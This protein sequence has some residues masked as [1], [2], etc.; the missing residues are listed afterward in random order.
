[1]GYV[2]V[3]DDEGNRITE[4]NPMPVSGLFGVPASFSKSSRNERPINVTKGQVNSGRIRPE[5]LNENAES[6]REAQSV[7]T[8]TNKVGQVFKASQDNINAIYLTLQSAEAVAIDDFESYADD[9]ALQ[10]VWTPSNRDNFI[11]TTIVRDGLQSMGMTMQTLNDEWVMTMAAVDYTG[12][13][14]SFDYFQDVTASTAYLSV[15][16]EDS[17]GNSKHAELLVN[18]A[19]NWTHFDIQEVA[20]IEDQAGIT[21]VTDIIKIGF[22]VDNS[23][24]GALAYIDNLSAAPAPGQVGIQIWDMGTVLPEAG[25]DSINDGTQYTQ[26]GDITATTP[27]SQYNLDL[28]GGKRLYHVHDFVCGVALE[29]PTNEILNVDHY[30]ALVLTYVDTDVTVYGPDSSFDD[31]PYYNNGYAFTAP[32]NS[33]AI[34]QI[35]VNND[36]MFS[37]FST[38]DVYIFGSSARA[39]AE[40]NGNSSFMSS[41]EGPQMETLDVVHTHGLNPPANGIIDLTNRPIFLPK[42]GKFNLDYNDDYTDEVTVIEFGMG[43][44]YEPPTING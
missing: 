39:N 38:Q 36:L 28:E 14:G 18:Q 7:V 8:S 10:A 32:D 31:A 22:R 19:N 13:T 2:I 23:R 33:T 26:I 11:E 42:G 6:S 27:V 43:Y 34:T 24:L 16:I 17:A 20:M 12:Y 44:L 15:F 3:L 5:V 4:E 40:P 1:M 9:V 25:V 41:I 21:D 30:Y 29:I 35:G 37:I